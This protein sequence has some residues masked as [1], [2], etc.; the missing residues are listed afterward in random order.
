MSFHTTDAISKAATYELNTGE[1]RKEL[2]EVRMRA[3]E[4]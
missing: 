2:G 1:N 4:A 3:W